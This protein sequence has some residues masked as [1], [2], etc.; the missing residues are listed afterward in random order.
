[1]VKVNKVEI[2]KLDL[3]EES[4]NKKNQA[5]QMV[6]KYAAEHLHLLPTRVKQTVGFELVDANADLANAIRRALTNEIE[7][8]A[9]DFDE[10]KDFDSSDPY[11]LSDFI[12]K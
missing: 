8:L 3:L 5:M 11:I 4:K 1:M 9:L 12:K 7:T 10:F 2:T 6:V